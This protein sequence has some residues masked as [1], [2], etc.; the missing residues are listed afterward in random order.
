M[1]SISLSGSIGKNGSTSYIGMTRKKMAANRKGIGPTTLIRACNS[2]TNT[3]T[4]YLLVVIHKTLCSVWLI[5]LRPEGERDG[6]KLPDCSSEFFILI[7]LLL[8]LI[9]CNSQTTQATE[10]TQHVHKSLHLY[11]NLHLSRKAHDTYNSSFQGQ[12][13]FLTALAIETVLMILNSAHYK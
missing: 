4:K 6:P 8:F 3:R 12:R 13:R 7:L 10:P 5:N 1:C 2:T 9:R 11:Y